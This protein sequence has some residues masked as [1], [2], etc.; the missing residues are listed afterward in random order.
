MP[1]HKSSVY[2]YLGYITLIAASEVS[3]FNSC[4]EKESD[5]LPPPP[6]SVFTSPSFY[7]NLLKAAKS[8]T[9][10]SFSYHFQQ[11]RKKKNSWSLKRNFGWNFNWNSW[12]ILLQSASLTKFWTETLINNKCHLCP[13]FHFV[14]L[15]FFNFSGQNL[16][17]EAELFIKSGFSNQNTSGVLGEAIV[18]SVNTGI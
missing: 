3:I 17:K 5:L 18:C 7:L 15:L 10:F 11:E 16:V 8:Q 4:T 1:E 2:S 13:L 14:A 6:I 12:R 9:I